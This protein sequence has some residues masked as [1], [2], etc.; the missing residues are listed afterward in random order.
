MSHGDIS[1][2]L[3]SENPSSIVEEVIDSA[4]P[5]KGLCL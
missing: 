4:G 2:A 3:F 1:L 5:K